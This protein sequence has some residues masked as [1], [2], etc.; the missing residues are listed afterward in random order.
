MHMH[1]Y[2]CAFR[3]IESVAVCG[4]RKEEGK[5]EVSGLAGLVIALGQRYIT[6]PCM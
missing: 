3:E 1:M 2:V 6:Y 4:K 5:E